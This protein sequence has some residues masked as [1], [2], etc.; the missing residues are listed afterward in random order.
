[1]DKNEKDKEI[2]P[3]EVDFGSVTDF[4][5]GKFVLVIKDDF[6]SDEE[7]ALFRQPMELNFC[8]TNDLAIFVLE[9]GPV[10]SGDFY[11]NVQESDAKDELLNADQLS[12]QVLL[13]DGMNRIC[14]KKNHDFTK[15]ESKEIID[16]LKKQSEVEFMP[17]EY[18]V[19]VEG[20]QSAYEPY[21]LN[22]FSKVKVRL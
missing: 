18:E 21:D 14:A 17:G 7:L 19:N 4:V 5:D 6:W 2:F 1:M 3:Y 8:Y 9:G 22:K 13:I 15:Q 11:F 16:L 10:D 20:L 12:I